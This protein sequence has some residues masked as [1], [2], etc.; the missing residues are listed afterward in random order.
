VN[1]QHNADITYPRTRNF[2]LA[3]GCASRGCHLAG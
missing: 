1:V 3:R 2:G